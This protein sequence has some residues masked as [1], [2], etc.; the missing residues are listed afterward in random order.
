MSLSIDIYSGLPN[1]YLPQGAFLGTARGNI[2]TI[3]AVKP[4]GSGTD[5]RSND[6]MGKRV[7]GG[8][9]QANIY[10]H[11]HGQV[12]RIFDWNWIEHRDGEK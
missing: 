1:A 10:Y 7:N 11:E 4:D 5:I 9:D 8:F 6:K 12:K 2:S 3:V